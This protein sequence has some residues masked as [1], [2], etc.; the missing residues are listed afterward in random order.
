MEKQRKDS[1]NEPSSS[2]SSMA[3]TAMKQGGALDSA[4]AVKQLAAIN[5]WIRSRKWHAT[6]AEQWMSQQT[7]FITAGQQK[8][9][10][11]Y[12]APRLILQMKWSPSDHVLI[13]NF[14][15][16]KESIP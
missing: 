1:G 10:I 2:S 14:D 5:G 11:F 13:E 16:S 8:Y 3:S 12:V 4:R 9:T 7:S 6:K 15:V